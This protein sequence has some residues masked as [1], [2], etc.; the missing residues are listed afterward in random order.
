MK[1]FIMLSGE[2]IINIY[3]LVDAMLKNIVKYD[4]AIQRLPVV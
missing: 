1:L 3:W 4:C 2:Y